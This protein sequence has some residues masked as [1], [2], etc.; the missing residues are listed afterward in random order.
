M[1]VY[2]DVLFAVNFS[3]DLLSLYA[4][5]AILSR[6]K[7]TVSLLL[8]SLLGGA[9]GVAEVLLSLDGWSGA[10]A[11]V[12]VSAA[13]CGIAYGRN[14]FFRMYLV[15]FGAEAFLGG[16]MSVL[17]TVASKLI[18]RSAVGGEENVPITP[19]GFFLAVA[20]S[21]A[22]GILTSKT[23]TRSAAGEAKVVA[24]FGGTTLTFTAVCDSGNVLRDPLSSKPVILIGRS[25][26]GSAFLTDTAKASGRIRLIPYQSVGGKGILVGQTADRLRI[27]YKGR[28]I[29]A[30]ALLA[31]A[32]DVWDFDGRGGCVPPVVL[33]A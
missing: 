4:A 26:K 22:V 21:V 10:I 24:T 19:A 14:G 17:Y 11:M 2:V 27:E 12:L 20:V 1:T 29:A 3:M 16:V 13:M 8:A 7:K 6:K 31:V 9:Y 18:N 30:D 32:E 15:F 5:G 23:L 25:V 28:E 33:R